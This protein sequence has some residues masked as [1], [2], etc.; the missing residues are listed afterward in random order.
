MAEENGRTQQK[1]LWRHKAYTTMNVDEMS[2]ETVRLIH[3]DRAGFC[4]RQPAVR[5][6]VVK[7]RS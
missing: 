3:S 4:F 7:N 2:E 1:A 5:G 6:E